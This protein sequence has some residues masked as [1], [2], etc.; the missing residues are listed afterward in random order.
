MYNVP[1]SLF[2]LRVRNCEALWS[3]SHHLGLITEQAVWVRAIAGSA[4]ISVF[5]VFFRG[6]G[7]TCRSHSASH[8]AIQLYDL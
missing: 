8:S 3:A 1:L 5:Y 4:E 2:F 6:E 7:K